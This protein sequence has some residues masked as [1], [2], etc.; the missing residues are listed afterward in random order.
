MINTKPAGLLSMLGI[1]GGE[2]PAELS[3][4]LSLQIEALPFY[5][6]YFE[7]FDDSTAAIV[8]GS[9][10]VVVYPALEAV[11]LNSL[12]YIIWASAMIQITAGV[13]AAYAQGWRL[14][15]SNTNVPPVTATT[16]GHL[17]VTNGVGYDF[18]P[19][20]NLKRLIL[21]PGDRLGFT[22]SSDNNVTAQIN[23]G[24]RYADFVL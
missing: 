24:I 17:R 13:G 4:V 15:R 8:T 22:V 5:L 14:L 23:F 10:K 21:Q 16:Y 20:S 3:D 19:Y 1:K 9:D 11:P 2:A 12:R 7:K 6:A 18:Q